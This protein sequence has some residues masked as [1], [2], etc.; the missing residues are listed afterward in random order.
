MAR[1]KT[2]K[3]EPLTVSLTAGAGASIK[4]SRRSPLSLSLAGSFSGGNGQF[5]YSPRSTGSRWIAIGAALSAKGRRQLRAGLA[6]R[7]RFNTLADLTGGTAKA[8]A[9]HDL[10]LAPADYEEEFAE[11]ALEIKQSVATG[12]PEFLDGKQAVVSIDGTYSATHQIEISLS[13]S[14]DDD[15]HPFGAPLT[16]PGEV[17][18]PRGMAERVRIDTTVF[19]SGAADA[20][21]ASG[22]TQEAAE[23]DIS[24]SAGAE[25]ALGPITLAPF[26]SPS[27]SATVLSSFVD[28]M[29][30]A[31]SIGREI[32]VMLDDRDD[33]GAHGGAFTLPVGDHPGMERVRL[34]A[35]NL[36][37]P[38]FPGSRAQI[39]VPEGCTLSKGWH[40]IGEHILI[41]NQ[42]TA[43]VP[44]AP[45]DNF[46]IRQRRAIISNEGGVAFAHTAN[47]GPGVAM[48]VILEDT[49][50]QIGPEVGGPTPVPVQSG[51]AYENNGFFSAML[52]FATDGSAINDDSIKHNPAH[53]TFLFLND[54]QSSL[55]DQAGVDFTDPNLFLF[56]N[57]YGDRW[58]TVPQI[59]TPPST[60]RVSPVLGARHRLDTSGGAIV[61]DLPSVLAPSASA[62]NSRSTAI[63]TEIQDTGGGGSLSVVGALGEEL[64]GVLSVG[65]FQ[66]LTATA[67]A[68][69]DT[70]TIGTEVYTFQDTLTDVQGNVKRTGTLAT[71]LANL[72]AHINGGAGAGTAYA[73]SG[74]ADTVVTAIS[75][76]TTL[77]ATARVGG[78]Q[79]NTVATTETSGTAA[80]G[81]ATLLGGLGEVAVAAGG[82][83]KYSS[84]AIDGMEKVLYS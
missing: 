4:V 33:S 70:V 59:G 52:I 12:A 68:D 16:A 77:T 75:D 58:T 47:L 30:L 71:D 17:V 6:A 63:D 39:I 9:L 61:Q 46:V 22:F 25:S 29:S 74:V 15:W 24:A 65:A 42:A 13:E 7:V 56:L 28:L 40:T 3:S 44:I 66:V 84:N 81:A 49:F 53:F 76:A 38:G 64:D 54:S 69:G 37:R 45:S 36:T 73:A 57:K 78:T 82:T 41:R 5:E 62:Q 19:A 20:L 50:S 27:S 35:I 80:W 8:Q 1:P 11:F 10:S 23:G 55:A 48:I 60:S 83:V 79:N 18:L 31:E 26:K 67:I 72:A 32:D 34:E 43:T 51:H 2:F 21:V 14:D